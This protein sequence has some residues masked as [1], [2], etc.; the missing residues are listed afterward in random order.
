MKPS[1][2]R[3]QQC[4][5]LRLVAQLAAIYFVSGEPKR[6]NIA[7]PNFAQ[8]KCRKSCQIYLMRPTRFHIPCLSFIIGLVCCAY[9]PF[10]HV[11]KSELQ[12]NINLVM[13]LLL[14]SFNK[15]RRSDARRTRHRV[16]LFHYFV[17]LL[18]P[19][20]AWQHAFYWFRAWHITTSRDAGRGNSSHS[21]HVQL[22]AAVNRQLFSQ[23]HFS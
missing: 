23:N 6:R 4:W 3:T 18:V 10:V 1:E 5:G 9:R 19:A 2:L 22:H 12:S 11:D 14:L 16:D 21:W 8:S 13:L 7:D 20:V 15:L 17:S